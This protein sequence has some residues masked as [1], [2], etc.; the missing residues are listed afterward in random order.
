[1]CA[2]GLAKQA[3][4]SGPWRLG[5]I[6]RVCSALMFEGRDFLSA[7][8]W[9]DSRRSVLP[10]GDSP[11][12]GD[13]LRCPEESGTSAWADLTRRNQTRVSPMRT[14]GPKCSSILAFSSYFRPRATTEGSQELSRPTVAL[15]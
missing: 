8:A 15:S 9:D 10:L 7:A 13:A 11:G 12:V 4:S 1:M 14:E 6:R 5:R 2:L 3:I